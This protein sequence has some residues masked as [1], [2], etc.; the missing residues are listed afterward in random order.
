MITFLRL[1]TLGRLGNQL[2]QYAALRS[3]SLENGYECKIPNP[4]NC[5]WDNQDC[6][7]GNFNIE[8]NY[9]T[10][11]D[12]QKIKYIYQ[13][14]DHMSYDE[15]FFN[16][17]DDTNIHGFFQSTHYLGKHSNQIRKELRTLLRSDN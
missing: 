15:N 2:F 7:L 11:Q 3:L 17:P 1:G 12:L 8:A 4:E 10:D 14:P 16:I 5:H 9:L 13:E 6:L